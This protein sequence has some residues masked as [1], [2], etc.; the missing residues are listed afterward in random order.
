MWIELF[1]D[2][3]YVAAIVHISSEVDLSI[4]KRGDHNYIAVVIPQWGMLIQTWHETVVFHNHNRDDFKSSR[5]LRYGS[6]LFMV[7]VFAMGLF[8]A[9]DRQYHSAFMT[10][11]IL[12]KLTVIV[13]H[14]VPYRCHHDDPL[15]RHYAWFQMISCSATILWLS[16]GI[17]LNSILDL[18]IMEQ[19]GVYLW[20]FLCENIQDAICNVRCP[21][22]FHIGHFVER[23]GLFVLI[24][25]GESIIASMMIKSNDTNK[26]V[27][28]VF[29][30]ITFS[31]SYCIGSLYYSTQ[32]TPHRLN[33]HLSDHHEDTEA[34]S[35]SY[36]NWTIHQILFLALLGWGMGLKLTQSRSYRSSPSG[37]EQGGV[38]RDSVVGED[39]VDI[40][41][42]GLSLVVITMVLM[43]MRWQHPFD[44][45]HP[46]HPQQ[47]RWVWIMRAASVASMAII[48]SIG[49]A[50]E[51][52]P[53][54][55]FAV[56]A[57]F[58]VGLK[59]LDIEG[60]HIANQ[61]EKEKRL[62]AAIEDG[63]EES[64]NDDV[65]EES[66][67]H[68]NMLSDPTSIGVRV[69]ELNDM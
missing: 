40:L 11:Y 17:V 66:K 41:L 49:S 57:L 10:S 36:W 26:V 42:P 3:I 63:N 32:P 50:V 23:L 4:T 21:M 67:D 43:W 22:L 65:M 45:D 52:A 35:P 56:L 6:Y 7:F 64:D 30:I 47:Q 38:G 28:V 58:V 53:V 24:I 18:G 48:V 54:V 68:E 69:S 15:C 34:M 29:A 37:A 9:D 19:F 2:L 44:E 8:I 51:L 16:V 39:V 27:L 62:S 1:F 14:S 61:L 55:V 46:S 25:L 5:T 12:A 59:A 33:L 13:M 60:R 31:I 20:C